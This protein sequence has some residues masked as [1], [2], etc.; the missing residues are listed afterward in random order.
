MAAELYVV[1]N[2]WRGIR[3]ATTATDQCQRREAAHVVIGATL[4]GKKVN[5]YPWQRNDARKYGDD[6]FGHAPVKLR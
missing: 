6:T 4:T 5:C 3:P 2:A 1:R